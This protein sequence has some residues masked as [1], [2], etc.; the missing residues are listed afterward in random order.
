MS[1]KNKDNALASDGHLTLADRVSN[2]LADFWRPLLGLL[3]VGLIGFAGW[4]VYG[5]LQSAR[6]QEQTERFYEVFKKQE[7]VERSIAEADQKRIEAQK[8]QAARSKTK[9]SPSPSEPSKG[10]FDKDFSPLVAEYR[11]L[12]ES[13]GSGDVAA[14]AA[15][16]GAEIL[17]RF[18]RFGDAAELLDKV[19]GSLDAD[20]I[21]YLL[22][23]M[24]LSYNL[25]QSD[26][27]DRAIQVLAPLA[28]SSRH[29]FAQA[30]ASIRLGV[31][32]L[33]QNNLP[34]ARAIFSR[35]ATEHAKTEAARQ[36]E[37]YLRWI[38]VS[39]R[40]GSNG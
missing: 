25:M 36:A 5:R 22:V 30:Q 28:K 20:S 26:Q 9:A 27:L 40:E 32:Y 15:L 39:G 33:R 13:F 24:S 35:I 12:V 6:L 37:G 38:E 14:R 34:E 2:F 3:L 21:L 17:Q 7:G 8:E 16:Q 10:D 1:N 31:A 23:R 18:S 11:G 29:K 4:M 19:A